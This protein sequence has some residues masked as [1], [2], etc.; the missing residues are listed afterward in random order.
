MTVLTRSRDVKS[1]DEVSRWSDISLGGI[2][3]LRAFDA[4]T[5]FS[6][7]RGL[8]ALLPLAPAEALIIR[9]CN[10]IHTL[11]M[12]C[13]I[14]VVFVDSQGCVLRCESVSR[15]RIIRCANAKAVVEM[16]EGSIDRLGIA[17]GA[18]LS[19]SRGAWA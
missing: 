19:R 11:T 12:P 6:R 3:I 16:S 14:D 4:N 9:P 1:T 18:V 13:T 2:D 8:H 5:F 10:A 17:E 15:R 7:L